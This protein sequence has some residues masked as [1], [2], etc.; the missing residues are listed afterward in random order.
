MSRDIL[1]TGERQILCDECE[2]V[3]VGGMKKSGILT[4]TDKQR[5]VFTVKKGRSEFYTDHEYTVDDID[6]V[7]VS[8]ADKFL[9]K[10]LVLLVHLIRVNSGQY[11]KI[12][13]QDFKNTSPGRW[14]DAVSNVHAQ[15]K[16]QCNDL[17]LAILKSH[18]R[19]SF[20]RVYE[21]CKGPFY[22][23]AYR[24][25]GKTMDQIDGKIE[26]ILMNVISTDKVEGFIDKQKREFVHKV[27]YQQ[28]SEVIQYQVATSFEFGTNGV[29][30][31][32]CPSCGASE[33][34]REKTSEVTC[35]YCRSVFI[36][37]KKI[38]DLI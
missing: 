9:S 8:V 10:K 1:K 30:L 28:K 34:R 16:Q 13:Y 36:I 6:S 11:T 29:L 26:E 3:Y 19:T 17:L 18:E 12:L 38:L 14:V 32:K 7:K 20:D 5:I 35:S 23:E 27:A 25:E 33:N 4:L 15:N 2:C 21:V 31:L 37:P 22:L 24:K